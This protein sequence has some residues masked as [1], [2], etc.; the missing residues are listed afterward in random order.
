[1]CGT[2]PHQRWRYAGGCQRIALCASQVSAESA[3]ELPTHLLDFCSSDTR[4]SRA[5]MEHIGG[6][7]R[8]RESIGPCNAGSLEREAQSEESQMDGQT[9]GEERVATD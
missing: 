9:G 3:G 6:F 8:S 7:K 5:N 4:Q 1:M 2:L